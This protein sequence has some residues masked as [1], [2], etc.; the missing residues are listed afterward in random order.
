MGEQRAILPSLNRRRLATLMAAVGIAAA[1]AA[2]ILHGTEGNAQC[3][4][5]GARF[6]ASDPGALVIR[7]C[8]M[9]P[10]PVGLP[11]SAITYDLQLRLLILAIPPMMR[12]SSV[13]GRFVDKRPS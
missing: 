11:G 12:N 3:P 10:L 1:G 8:G 7:V 5:F 13:D 2:A 6:D 4:A 9:I